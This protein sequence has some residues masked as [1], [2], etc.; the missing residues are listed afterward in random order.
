MQ[1]A[2]KEMKNSN[3]SSVVGKV[4]DEEIYLLDSIKPWQKFRL[5]ESK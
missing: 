4:V 2:L 1:I 5:K 3:R